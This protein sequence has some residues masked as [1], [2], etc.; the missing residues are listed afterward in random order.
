MRS[1]RV[2]EALVLIALALVGASAYLTWVRADPG[3]GRSVVD[4][5]GYAVSRAPVTMVLASVVAVVVLR[6]AGTLV[7]RILCA[8]VAAMGVATIAVA[9][10]VRPDEAELATRKPALSSVLADHVTITTGPA[11]WVALVG[12]IALLAAGLAGL[13]TAHRWR[14]P[15][16]KYERV[17]AAGRAETQVD[18][19]KAIDAGEDPTI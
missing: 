5:D 2:P 1:Q 14:R 6:L 4:F 13:A 7:R 19:W 11:P 9:L 3:G 17:Q 12:G 10:A 15:T 8:L 16:S 18:Q